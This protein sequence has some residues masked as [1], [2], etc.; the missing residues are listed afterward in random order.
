MQFL[1]GLTT[2]HAAAELHS[3][4]LGGAFLPSIVFMLDKDGEL[5]LQVHV[6]QTDG[7]PNRSTGGRD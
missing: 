4:A 6:W 1:P 3:P 2:S 5:H 7:G